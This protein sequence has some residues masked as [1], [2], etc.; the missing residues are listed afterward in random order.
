LNELLSNWK[1]SARRLTNGFRRSLSLFVEKL[2]AQSAEFHT[3]GLLPNH[4]LYRSLANVCRWLGNQAEALGVESTVLPQLKY[5]ST[6]RV[7]SRS[8]NEATLVWAERPAHGP[9]STRHGTAC[10]IHLVR[11]RVSGNL[12]KQLQSRFKLNEGRD[13]QVYGIGLKGCGK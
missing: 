5:C 12:G 3:A 11:R 2:G 7:M 4:E 6:R 1:N 9:L 13:P 10:Q 8:C